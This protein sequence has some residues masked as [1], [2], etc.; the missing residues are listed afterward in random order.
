MASPGLREAP[1][2]SRYVLRVD[3][4]SQDVVDALG[5]LVLAFRDVNTRDEAVIRAISLMHQAIGRDIVLVAANGT[6]S[7]LEGVWA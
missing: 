2:G 5:R 3:L 7:T 6:E 1:E 4:G